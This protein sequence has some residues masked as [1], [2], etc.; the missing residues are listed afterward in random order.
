MSKRPLGAR[1]SLAVISEL[2]G[3]LSG[4]RAKHEGR[5]GQVWVR[6]LDAAS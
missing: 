3:G 5:V 6:G 1:P 4:T 2:P